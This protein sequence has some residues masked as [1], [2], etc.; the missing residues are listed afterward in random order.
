M[1]AEIASILGYVADLAKPLLKLMIWLGSL[2]ATYPH[3]VVAG[4]EQ[5]RRLRW[6]IAQ[7]NPPVWRKCEFLPNW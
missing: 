3:S 4:T 5:A 7:F 2:T 6:P 1:A